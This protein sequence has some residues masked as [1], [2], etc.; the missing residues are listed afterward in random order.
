MDTLHQRTKDNLSLPGLQIEAAAEGVY[1]PIDNR[2]VTS[3][4]YPIGIHSSLPSHDTCKGG[5]ALLYAACRR[6]HS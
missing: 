6:L 2:R 3:R 1:R 4:D 5:R